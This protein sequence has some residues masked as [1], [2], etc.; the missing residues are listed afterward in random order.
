VYIHL[1]TTLSQEIAH[2]LINTSINVDENGTPLNPLDAHFRSLGLKS[3]DPVAQNSSE[4]KALTRYISDTHGQTHY[5]RSE[6]VHAFRVE[7]EGE[8]SAW[9]AKGYDKLP[10]GD[11]MLLWHGSRTTNFAGK[12]CAK[13]T[14]DHGFTAF[15]QVFLNRAFESPLRRRLLRVCY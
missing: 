2:E 4:F 11:R 14:A 1:L 6:V 12:K 8:T 9:L 5:F 15:I 13:Y 3:M 7:R 10:A